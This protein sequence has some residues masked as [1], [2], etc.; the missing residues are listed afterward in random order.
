[1]LLLTIY[2]PTFSQLHW[3]PIKV[4][5]SLKKKFFFFKLSASVSTALAPLLLIISISCICT[6]PLHLF[7]SNAATCL[8]RHPIYKL[9]QTKSDRAVTHFGPSVWSSQPLNI[10]NAA[11][12]DTFKSA[13]K[14]AFYKPP[15]NCLAQSCWTCV[16]V[17][18]CVCNTRV[19]P[20]RNFVAQFCLD[21]CA[22][23]C[24]CRV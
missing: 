12:I 5:I 22:R 1:M 10:R 2:T 18:V 11:T 24:V 20:T 7:C 17:C 21:F 16:C 3:L 6:V 14:T 8:L 4:R 9:C 13:L 19:Q 23:V 15:K